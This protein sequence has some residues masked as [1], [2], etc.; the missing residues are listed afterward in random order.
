[1]PPTPATRPRHV[2]AATDNAMRANVRTGL[3][4]RSAR[5]DLIGPHSSPTWLWPEGGGG[6]PLSSRPRVGPGGA[7]AAWSR[8][9]QPPA[10]PTQARA[11]P[12][13]AWQ[14]SPSLAVEEPRRLTCTPNLGGGGG[15]DTPDT[16]GQ[17][18]V[19]PVPMWLTAR[20]AA[21]PA[22]CGG[23]R[24]PRTRRSCSGRAPPRWASCAGRA[25]LCTRPRL[26][27]RGQLVVPYRRCC[28]RG[29][30]CCLTS[31]EAKHTSCGTVVQFCVHKSG[32]HPPV[33]SQKGAIVLYAQKQSYPY[34]SDAQKP[35]GA[36]AYPEGSRIALSLKPNKVP[37]VPRDTVSFP[38]VTQ[39]TVRVREDSRGTTCAPVPI[40]AHMLSPDPGATMTSSDRPKVDAISALSLPMGA[41]GSTRLSGI[42]FGRSCAHQAEVRRRPWRRARYSD[43]HASLTSCS[44]DGSSVRDGRSK[45]P[46]PDASP[47][48]IHQRSVRR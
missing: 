14:A 18:H 42:L 10:R 37:D 35:Q 36:L 39:P 16:L 24:P 26:P 3:E 13:L 29:R 48:S 22:A 17:L 15:G 20:T 30:K 28:A 44:M 4:F 41:F 19:P 34:C 21:R 43:R 38:G 12:V 27:L 23:Q 45:R 40:A 8:S 5:G 33:A 31:P 9:M 6:P 46:I 2:L 32:S 1:M 25:P 11:R 47:A 7:R